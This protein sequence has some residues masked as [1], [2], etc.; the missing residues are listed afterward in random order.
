MEHPALRNVGVTE[1][2]PDHFHLLADIK[3]EY[4]IELIEQEM[5]ELVGRKSMKRKKSSSR[6][7]VRDDG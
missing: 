6:S 2:Q 5:E 7:I 3:G 1:L 4:P